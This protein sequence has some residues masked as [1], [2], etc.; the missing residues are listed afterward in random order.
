MLIKLNFFFSGKI[1][2]GFDAFDS[3]LASTA[4]STIDLRRSSW[5][6]YSTSSSVNQLIFPMRSKSGIDKVR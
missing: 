6:L 4:V 2:V 5:S 1:Q 3:I